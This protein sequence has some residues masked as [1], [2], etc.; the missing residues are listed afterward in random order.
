MMGWQEDSYASVHRVQAV[1]ARFARIAVVIAAV[2]GAF[3]ASAQEPDQLPE[4]AVLRVLDPDGT[5]VGQQEEAYE[6]W[7]EGSTAMRRR[8]ISVTVD[9]HE[10]VDVF[11][12]VM[13]TSEDGGAHIAFEG[14]FSAADDGVIYLGEIAGQTA[15]ITRTRVSGERTVAE[16]SYSQSIPEG[17]PIADPE[18]LYPQLSGL[19][20]AF[21]PASGRFAEYEALSVPQPAGSR[22]PGSLRIILR[23]NYPVDL[24][25]IERGEDG[26]LVSATQ[27]QPGS[28]FRYVPLEFED[29]DPEAEIG[30]R[31]GHPMIESPHV[32]SAG[33]KRR[34]IRYRVTLAQALAERLPQTAQ[35]AVTLIDNGAQIDICGTCGPGLPTDAESLARWTQPT[36]WLQSDYDPIVRR[37]QS[38]ARRGSSD[39]RTLELLGEAVRAR[40][41]RVDFSGHYSARAAWERRSG[42]CTEDAVLLAALARAAGIPTRVVSGLAYTR[43]RYHGARNAFIPHAWVVAYVDGAWVSYDMTLDEGFGAGHIALT[44][45]D[46]EASQMAGANMI[47]GM[48]EWQGLSEVRPR[49]SK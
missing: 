24:R 47:A 2:S 42:D 7:A 3:G 35:Q 14:E 45:G 44:I 27:P 17:L 8:F 43:D 39:R 32:I 31:V 23:D 1:R 6:S 37:A 11:S 40:M 49:P 36:P 25:V 4:V 28:P 30:G 41:L 46:G 33:A 20:L 29:L 38:I 16:D 18:A 15:Q 5:L 10:K 19:F 48:L 21:D 12:R 34:H 9:G 26:V 13:I 22:Y